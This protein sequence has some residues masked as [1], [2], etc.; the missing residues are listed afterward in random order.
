MLLLLVL[1][2]LLLLLVIVLLVPLIEEAV[3]DVIPEREPADGPCME[4]RLL[5]LLVVP[6]VIVVFFVVGDALMVDAGR[7]VP[8]LCRRGVFEGIG[9][10]GLFTVRPMEERRAAS[11]AAALVDIGSGG[12]TVFF[13]VVVA[14]VAGDGDDPTPAAC[15]EDSLR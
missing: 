11:L 4:S 3:G 6:G 8:L 10:A 13:F 2:L 7:V 14:G 5:L 1:L 15:K 12:F 9:E